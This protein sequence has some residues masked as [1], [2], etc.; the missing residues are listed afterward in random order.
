MVQDIPLHPS[1]HPLIAGWFLER[2]GVPTEVQRLAWAEIISGGHVLIVAPTGSGKTLAAFLWAL[3]Q[4]VTGKWRPGETRVA[5]V[6]P[7]RALNNDIRRNLLKPLAG[8]RS[9]FDRAGR[10]IPEIRVLTRSGDTEPSMR[11][12]MQRHPPEILITTPESLNLLLS[13]QGGRSMLR[14]LETVILDEVHAVVGT[15]RGTHLITAVERLVPLAGEFQRIS[16]SATV[17]PAETVARFVGGLAM[18]GDPSNPRF[19][20][21]PVSLVEA[22]AAK[23]FDIRVRFPRAAFDREAGESIW[24]PLADEFRRI[25]DRNRSTLFFTNSRR[26]CEKVTVTL[27]RESEEPVAHAHHGSLSREI[28]E[29]V[30]RKLKDGE[31][32]AIVATNSL[33]L[34]IDIGDLDE[35][36]LIQSPPSISSAIQRVGRAGHR[37][38][39]VSRGEFFPTHSQDLIE[40][41]VLA[42]GMLERDLEATAPVECPLDVLAQIIV[43]MVGVERWNID[44]LHARLRSAYPYRNLGRELLDG[45]LNMLAGRYADSRIRELSARVSL[46]R[47]DNTV[48]ARP[49]ALLAVYTSGGTIPDRGYY[50]LRHQESNA[51]IGELDEE[52][53]FEASVGQVFTLGTQNWRIE[54]ITHNDVFVSPGN[55]RILAAP[56]WIGEGRNR[57]FHFSERILEFLEKAD[58]GTDSPEFVASLANEYR[59]EDAAAEE[60]IAY[61]KRQREETRCGL[62]HRH[63]VLLEYV[64]SGPGG[65]PGSQ[66]VLHTF[67]GGRVNRPFAMALEA[68]WEDRFGGQRVEVFTGDDCIVLQNPH[69]VRGEELLSL[70]TVANVESLLRKRLEGSGFFGARFRECAGRALLLTRRRVSERVPLWMTR[71]RSQKL[72]EAV[73]RYGDFPILLEAWRTCLQDEFDMEGLRQVLAELGSGAIT[74]SEARTATPSPMARSTT[75]RQISE[76]MYASDEQPS[77][78]SSRLRRDLLRD[79]VFTPGL[80]PAV[81]PDLARRFELKRQRLAPGYSPETPRDLLDWVKDRI[82]VPAA[83]WNELLDAAERDHGVA[84]GALL[85]PIAEKLVHVTFAGGAEEP[86][87]AARESAPRLARVFRSEGVRFETLAGAPLL[88]EGEEAGEAREDDRMELLGEWLQYYGPMTPSA[89]REKLGLSGEGRIELAL[90]DL[91]DADRIIAGRLLAGG[92]ENEICDA[93]NFETLLRLSRA[94]AV[95]AVEAAPAATLPLFLAHYQGVTA[96][97]ADADGLAARIQ[98]LAFYPAEASLWESEILPARMHPYSTAIL[99]S[100][101]QEGEIRWIGGDNRRVAF[102]LESDLDLFRDESPDAAEDLFPDP[103]GRYDFLTLA[104]VLGLDPQELSRRLWEAVFRGEVTNDTFLAL[105]KGILGGFRIPDT[106]A[107]PVSRAGARRR[108]LRSGFERWKG[109]LPFSGNWFRIPWPEA[110][111]DPLEREELNKDRTRVLLDRYGILFRELLAHEAPAFGWSGV[112]RSLRLMELAGEVLAGHFFQG[113]PGPQFISH[114]ALRVLQR[115]LPEDAVFWMS[116]ADPASLCGVAVDAFKGKLPKRL[117]GTHLVYR[118][119]EPVVISERHGRVLRIDISPDDPRLPEVFGFLSHFL[120]RLFRPMRYVRVETINGDEAARS[121]YL[122]P[123]RTSFDVA[124]EYRTVILYRKRLP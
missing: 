81:S 60:L 5:Y 64:A 38:G 19:T 74:W 106:A 40:A 37:V 9:V 66:L 118:G 23:P 15:K 113:I 61:L 110:A 41:A 21:R 112:F 100:L 97:A 114:R 63:R 76:Y 10:P 6:S 12:R 30:E 82:L 13:S 29:E 49:G 69:D 34:G 28:R 111:G 89:L 11:A 117:S 123:L 85:Q 36:V 94:E 35:V 16:L 4:L 33:E 50:H 95:P 18:E 104:R 7:L 31:L 96:P 103:R 14:G 75:W 45:V 77:G 122:D 93:G 91:L 52:F 108:P 71:L 59:M 84:P 32:K 46:D 43:S 68:A 99:D 65:V 83:E 39:E 73:S 22:G 53:V 107:L 92:A 90:E 2:V 105:R 48:E 72:C 80:R 57:D 101:M 62:P 116:A 119:R 44:A 88:F 121:P 70:V 1:F 67:W 24:E 3:N 51:L 109:A 79:V 124:V 86:A 102:C 87:N 55:P 47:L 26:L 8:L 120:T 42:R 17:N 54:R 98:Q 25:I 20:P 58:G 56:F 115:K 27:N 78:R